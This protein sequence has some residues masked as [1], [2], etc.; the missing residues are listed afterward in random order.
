MA[1]PNLQLLTDA[2]KLLEPTLGELVF[3]GWLCDGSVDH[4]RGGGC[5]TDIPCGRDRR[6]H[7]KA[8][9]SS[10]LA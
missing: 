5:A 10:F 2:A 8:G 4:R 1:N 7:F 3:C 9:I 6:G